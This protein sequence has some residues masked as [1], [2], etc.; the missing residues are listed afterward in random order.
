MLELYLE[1]LDLQEPL[2]RDARAGKLD[3]RVAES[4]LVPRFRR[5]VR[6]VVP[7]ATEVLAAAGRTLEEAGDEVRTTLLETFLGRDAVDE[8]AAALGL[9]EL[10]LEFFARAFLQPIAEAV[11][12]GDGDSPSEKSCP[13]C[14]WPPQVGVVRDELEVKGRRYLVC[15]FCSAWWP[16][17]RSTCPEC[18]ETDPEKL[19]Y[20][21]SE[22]TPHVRVDECQTCR[23]YLK[24]VDLR[25]DGLA[26][27][28]VEDIATVELDVW[29]AERGLVKIRRSLLGL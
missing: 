21:V 3:L 26:V 2:Y 14:G 10:Q 15:S 9:D 8:V 7:A 24:S 25:K 6:E 17:R 12:E 13:R 5:F 16:C 19:V 1:L 4:R 28:E 29:S 20:H 11:H 18:G 27:P 23:R 22:P